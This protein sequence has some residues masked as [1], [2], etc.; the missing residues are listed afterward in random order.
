[1]I[2]RHVKVSLGNFSKIA[3]KCA[4][5]HLTI[6]N[7]NKYFYSQKNPYVSMFN[8]FIKIPLESIIYHKYSRLCRYDKPIGAFLLYW[9]C[10]WGVAVGS[11]TMPSIINII[12]LYGHFCCFLWDHGRLDQQD[13]SL[14][15]IQIN[16]S[17]KKCKDAK[18]GP[19][20]LVK[21]L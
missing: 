11:L 3:R 12:Q 8:Q 1:M 10:A 7:S 5:L 14:T 9:P 18:I 21:S 6:N 15:I 13:A 17:I 20:L 16:N 4:N 2:N 19:W